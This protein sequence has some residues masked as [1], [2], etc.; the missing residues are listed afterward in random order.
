MVWFRRELDAQR[1]GMLHRIPDASIVNA[2]QRD[3]QNT[4][5]HSILH[6]AENA[7]HI[8]INTSSLT[9]GH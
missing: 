9:P 7:S 8:S 3:V 4:M 5:R 1:I 2:H 6:K